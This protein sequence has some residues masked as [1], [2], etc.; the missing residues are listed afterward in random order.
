[1]PPPPPPPPK[2][3][4]IP[5]C[6]RNGNLL[7]ADLKTRIVQKKGVVTGAQLAFTDITERKLAEEALR[8]SET[9]FRDLAEKSVVGIYLIQEGRF[10]YVNQKFAEMWGYRADDLMN[11]TGPIDA[12]VPVDKNASER[13][14]R[15]WDTADRESFHDE[16]CICMKNQELRHAEVYGSRTVYRGKP[17]VIGTL[18][19]VTVRKRME[20]E[21]QELQE[22]LYHSE[23][24]E[25]LGVLAGGVAHDLNNVLGVLTG[26]SELLLLKTDKDSPAIRYITNIMKSSERAAAIVNDLLTLARRGV[27]ASEIV[28]LNDMVLECQ[29]TPEFEKLRS[30]HPLVR[31]KTILQECLPN[32][33][34][35]PVHLGKMVMNLI[36]NAAEAMDQGGPVTVTTSRRYLETPVEGYEHVSQGDYVVLSVADTGHGISESDMKR[37]FEPF[38][39]KKVM[40]RSGTGLGLTVVWGTVKDHNGYIDVQSEEGK[41][42]TFTLYFPATEELIAAR[43]APVPTAELLGRKEAILVVDDVREQR[44]IAAQMLSELN[45]EV[46]TAAGGEEAL[47]YLKEHHADLIVL[48][49]IMDPG[50][51]GL[52][53]YQRILETCGPQK[54]VIV[55]GFAETDRVKKVQALGAGA[56]IRKPY[57]MEKLGIEVR[58]ELDRPIG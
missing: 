52:D 1:M 53:T 54:A 14:P 23:K 13:M 26:Y 27:H 2:N 25:A 29:K 9:K 33:K 7:W 35:S 4:E 46:A 47:T 10:Q 24:M 18:L 49:M 55:S 17:A 8:E 42:T 58:K 38:Y 51:D 57:A 22:R 15:I 50:M 6:R 21:R 34:G 12:I 39:T 44:D 30:F 5:I 36:S 56:Y 45:Y 41:G 16:F 28:D 11:Y 3:L 20:K 37:I 43:K 40:G 32:I 31:V 19:D 48:D